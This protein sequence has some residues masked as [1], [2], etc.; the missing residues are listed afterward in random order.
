M[1]GYFDKK[2]NEDEPVDGLEKKIKNEEPS[3]IVKASEIK[4]IFKKH[5]Q[6]IA[7]LHDEKYEDWDNKTKE[8]REETAKKINDIMEKLENELL[9]DL[10]KIAGAS[11]EDDAKKIFD[12]LTD[13]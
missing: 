6:K 9:V 7:E 11:S 13:K 4:R 1:S 12:N 3:F 10:E 2:G 5:R 8:Q